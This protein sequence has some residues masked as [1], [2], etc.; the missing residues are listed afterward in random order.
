MLICLDN[1][2]GSTPVLSP[3]QSS[4]RKGSDIIS[5]DKSSNELSEIYSSERENYKDSDNYTNSFHQT[6]SIDEFESKHSIRDS[7]SLPKYKKNDYKSKG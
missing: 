4:A 6:E 2:Y 1:Q 5:R 3:F 7:Y